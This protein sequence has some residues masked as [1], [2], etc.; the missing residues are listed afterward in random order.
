MKV[1]LKEGVFAE[2]NET[3]KRE[4][5]SKGRLGCAGI[6]CAIINCVGCVLADTEDATMPVEEHNLVLSERYID[7]E[8]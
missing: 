8:E 5:L 6:N 4:M 7:V 2:V 3:G 1:E